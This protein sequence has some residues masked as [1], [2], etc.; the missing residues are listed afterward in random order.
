[1]PSDVSKLMIAESTG[2]REMSRLG[3]SIF[4][5]IEEHRI[6]WGSEKGAKRRL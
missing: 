3:S 1:M 2:L 6:G 4:Q 5:A